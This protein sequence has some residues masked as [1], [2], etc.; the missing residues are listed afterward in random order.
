MKKYIYNKTQ[1][2]KTPYMANMISASDEYEDDYYDYAGFLREE[3][4]DYCLATIK[5]SKSDFLQDTP[6]DIVDN[7]EESIMRQSPNCTIDI[8]SLS[9]YKSL[10]SGDMSLSAEDLNNPGDYIYVKLAYCVDM[11]GE[12]DFYDYSVLNN[13]IYDIKFELRN[14]E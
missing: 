7:L 1:E 6:R 9:T 10:Q 8:I 13:A 3:Y 12:Y 11:N 4:A 5:Y 2:S 14:A